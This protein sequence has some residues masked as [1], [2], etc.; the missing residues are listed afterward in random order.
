MTTIQFIEG[1]INMCR[2]MKERGTYRLFHYVCFTSMNRGTAGL[3]KNF[4][5]LRKNWGDFFKYGFLVGERWPL[6]KDHN[7]FKLRN[8]WKD[9]MNN[10]WINVSKKR[11]EKYQKTCGLQ[12]IFYAQMYLQRT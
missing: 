2:F 1:Y 8:E 11:T 6:Y 10:K 7:L 5:Q 4:N 9:W 3:F 12:D